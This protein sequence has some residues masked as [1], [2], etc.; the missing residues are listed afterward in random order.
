MAEDIVH[1]TPKAF[2]YSCV[3]VTGAAGFVGSRLLARLSASGTHVI[4]L[5]D[6]SVGLPLPQVSEFVTPVL[7]DIR[8]RNL[9][10]AVFNDHRPQAIVHLAALHH[11]PTCEANPHLALDI[12]V[13]GTQILL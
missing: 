6:Q 4:A 3:L 8:N 12:N 5:D 9:M 7:A 13:M 10:R 1:K 2:P 11:I